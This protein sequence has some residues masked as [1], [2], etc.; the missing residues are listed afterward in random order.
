M[1]PCRIDT[2]VCKAAS[3]EKQ[4]AKKK[5]TE[6]IKSHV[7]LPCSCFAHSRRIFRRFKTRAKRD[8]QIFHT[9]NSEQ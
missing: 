4:K 9:F 3:K 8:E 1:P 7:I 6:R 5:I 2:S